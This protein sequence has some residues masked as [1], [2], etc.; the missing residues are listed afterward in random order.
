MDLE[1]VI[2][3]Y[4]KSNPDGIAAV[5][6]FGSQASGRNHPASDID[7]ALLFDRNDPEFIRSRIEETLY[8]LPRAVRREVHP[9]VMNT[10]SEV[11]LKQILGKGRCLLVFDARKLAEFKMNALA[12]IVDYSYYL[13]R[14]QNGF[15]RN[16][17]ES[18]LRD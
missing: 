3:D 12:R 11:L 4:F 16:L 5:Y 17:Q 13:K 18:E 6:L 14:L 10:G 7:I 2:A 9:V 15:I 8:K 1:E